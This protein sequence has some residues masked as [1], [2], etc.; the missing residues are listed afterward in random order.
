VTQKRRATGKSIADTVTQQEDKLELRLS[1]K[2][3]NSSIPVIN[4]R[5]GETHRWKF[6]F[7]YGK[8]A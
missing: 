2:L 1:F 7:K 3:T 4:V 8:I 5:D 6:E